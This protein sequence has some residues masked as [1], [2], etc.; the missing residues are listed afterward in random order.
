MVSPG[1]PADDGRGDCEIL[2]TTQADRLFLLLDPHTRR[3][4]DLC[5]G[6]TPSGDCPSHVAGQRLTCAGYRVVPLRRTSA[7]GLPFLVGEREG[8][9]CPLAWLDEGETDAEV[10]RRGSRDRARRRGLDA[11]GRPP[12]S[13]KGA[14]PL[15]PLTPAPAEGLA[16]VR[17]PG[18]HRRWSGIRSGGSA[19]CSAWGGSHGDGGPPPARARCSP[20]G[21]GSFPVTRESKV[22]RL[23]S[24]V[25]SQCSSTVASSLCRSRASATA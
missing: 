21:S 25:C 6:P 7:N 14:L 17:D 1:V 4:V 9:R 18:P 20:P 13:R 8:P 3:V 23:I 15:D 10:R 5:T 24:A 19:S 2:M 11:T 12:G 16:A 22:I